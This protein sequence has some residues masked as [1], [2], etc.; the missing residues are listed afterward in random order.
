MRAHL[1]RRCLANLRA[2][3][4]KANKSRVILFPGQQ[5]FCYGKAG[6]GGAGGGGGGSSRQ[7]RIRAMIHLPIN[8]PPSSPSDTPTSQPTT[9]TQRQ[10]AH[11]QERKGTRSVVVPL[12]LQALGRNDDISFWHQCMTNFVPKARL[13]ACQSP[14]LCMTFLTTT[15]LGLGSTMSA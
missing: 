8:R 12:P 5:H 10:A 9:T 1:S 15:G 7:H 2:R 13:R 4:C 6:A 3:A 11:Y 14:N